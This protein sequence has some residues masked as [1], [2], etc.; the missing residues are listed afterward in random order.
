MHSN[1]V[2]LKKK[3]KNKQTKDRRIDKEGI[4]R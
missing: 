4:W 1:S 3:K 2:Q